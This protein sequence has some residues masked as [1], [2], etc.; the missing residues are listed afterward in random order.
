MFDIEPYYNWRDYYISEED[1]RSPFYLK[2]YN[3]FDFEHT[4]YNY[5][6][7]PQWD[8]IGSPTLYIKILF[9]D[10]DKG[11]AIIELMGEWNDIITND[12]MLLKRDIVDS[13]LSYEINKFIL[14][15]ENVL[16]FHYDMEDYYEEWFD[17]VGDGWVAAI[18][19][20]H[21]VLDEIIKYHL[22]QYMVVGGELNNLEWRTFKP[23][24]LYKTVEQLVQRRIA[25][26][27]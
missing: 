19:L 26:Q 13:M 9:A 17:D 3:E 24:I 7:H 18:S 14:I 27:G 20:Q 8:D 12:V 23:Q 1:E 6:I 25:L 5:Y 10:Y 22:D 21:Y 2:E 4:I 15:G 11:F 16:N